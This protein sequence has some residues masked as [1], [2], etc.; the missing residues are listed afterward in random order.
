[1][2]TTDRGTYVRNKLEKG[3]KTEKR[4]G[5]PRDRVWDEQGW[6]RPMIYN[7][8]RFR[9]KVLEDV[10]DEDESRGPWRGSD[11]RSL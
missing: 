4:K 8:K 1:M 9:D 11:Y 2:V 10:K 3:D 7:L 6:E 5:R